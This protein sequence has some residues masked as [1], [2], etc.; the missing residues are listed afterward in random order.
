MLLLVSSHPLPLSLKGKLHICIGQP[1]PVHIQAHTAL[2]QH[3]FY[4]YAAFKLPFGRKECEIYI[5]MPLC[6]SQQKLPV[7]W[8]INSAL[9]VN[10]VMAQR[11]TAACDFWST[12]DKTFFQ[13][14]TS[15]WHLGTCDPFHIIC[16]NGHNYTGPPMIIEV[17]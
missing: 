4:S 6:H 7:I 15:L 14:S 8:K 10:L 13:M 9:T 17:I 1:Y 2:R 5:R 11:P 12:G 3:L 16:L